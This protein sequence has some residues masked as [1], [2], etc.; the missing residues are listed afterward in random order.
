ME[1]TGE[2][3]NRLREHYL[4]IRKELSESQRQLYSQ[5]IQDHLTSWKVYQHS[6]T[7]H[8]FLTIDKDGEV[9]SDPLLSRM[10]RDGKRVVVARPLQGREIGR[11]HY[12]GPEQH[13]V[14]NLA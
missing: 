12:S 2:A 10:M 9:Q 13:T 8:C 4:K 14:N 1:S 11:I 5:R 3:Q 6:Q 7:I